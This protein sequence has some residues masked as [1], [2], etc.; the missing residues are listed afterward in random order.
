MKISLSVRVAESPKNKRVVDLALPEIVRIA[1]SAGYDAICMRASVVG[2]QSS[3]EEVQHAGEE[4]ARS[5]LKVSMVTGDYAVPENE[6]E[7][8]GCLRN[9]TPHLDLTEALECD[10]IRICMKGEEDIRFAQRAS[11]EAGERGIRLAHQSH[12]C[13]LFETVEGSLD[14]LKRVGRSNFGLIYEPANLALCGEDYGPDVLKAFEPFLFNVYVKNQV[15]DPEGAGF[16]ETWV[17]GRIRSSTFPLDAPE[18]IDFDRVFAGL[19][20][21]GYDGYVTMHQ[22]FGGVVD[23]ETA[24]TETGAFLKHRC[25]V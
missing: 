21:I 13:S 6:A 20:A 1:R 15:P 18:G 5:G 4:I 12:I 24:A 2:V 8:P 3:E 11:D 7:G 16:T 17:K 25:S 9:I 14:V 19:F 10:L 23:P 22:A